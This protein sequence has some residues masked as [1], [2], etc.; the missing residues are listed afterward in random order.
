M[1]RVLV[2]G[3]GGVA[4]VAVRKCCQVSDVFSELCIASRTK[5]KC[6]ALAASLADKTET[7]ITTA[8]VN[9]DNVQEV[10][11][12]I[13]SYRPE[14][15]MNI[16]LPYQDLTIMDACLACGVH[17][18]DTA[19]Y[20]PEDTDDPAWRK[21]YEKRCKEAGFSAYFDYS[22]QW[23]Y[24]ERF[25]KAGLLRFSA[26]ALIPVSHRHIVHTQKSTNLTVSIP[27]ISLTAMAVIM[28]ILSQQISIPR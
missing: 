27:L 16:A 3:C 18:M 9:A 17:Y 1:S 21:I 11:G 26:A 4:N 25:E 7:K 12:L 19:N 23:A 10:I 6:D 5:S 15:V 14:L 28:D 2:I 8:E 24:R 22:W 13:R 20:E